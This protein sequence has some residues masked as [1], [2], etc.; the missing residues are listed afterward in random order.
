MRRIV[1]GLLLV[2]AL[3]FA[4]KNRLLAQAPSADRF[5]EDLSTN[6]VCSKMEPK[7]SVE[8]YQILSALSAASPAG[9]ERAL[10]AVLRCARPGNI[11][12]VRTVALDS[13][14]AVAVRPDGADLLSSKSGE[15]SFLIADD[16]PAI[17]GNVVSL[18][19]VLMGQ[20]ATKNKPYVAALAAAVRNKRT[21]LDVAENMI[22]FLAIYGR[23]DS[24]AAESVLA[25]L[26][27]DDLPPSMRS[28]L[29]RDLSALPGL[30]GDVR[31]YLLDRFDDPVPSVRAAAVIAF[32][33][34]TTEFHSLAKSRV[35]KIVGDSSENSG[36]RELAKK[37]LAGQSFAWTPNIYVTPNN[38]TPH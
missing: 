7:Q 30:P 34:S 10:P 13:L 18:V 24:D 32:A 33:D 26:H 20:P 36:V 3:S 17:Q 5:L 28:D 11:E 22:H 9:V 37:A 2:I 15:I 38:P 8:L 14:F 27:R 4:C 21:P 23:N 25:F 29:L 1:T 16:D 19:G 12:A 6:P 35:E 31:Q